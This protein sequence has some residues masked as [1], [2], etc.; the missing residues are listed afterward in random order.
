MITDKTKTKR[1]NGR[2]RPSHWRESYGGARP[3]DRAETC[4]YCDH[5]LTLF[6]QSKW[7]YR[8]GPIGNI[9]KLLICRRADCIRAAKEE[10]WM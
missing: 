4:P 7:V 1:T 3:L 5:R 9:E 10:R 2:T 8:Y 6:C